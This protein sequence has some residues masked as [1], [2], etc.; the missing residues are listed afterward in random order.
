MG[1]AQRKYK[2]KNK[3]KKSKTDEQ[4]QRA[5]FLSADCCC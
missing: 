5:S 2:I 4:K 3:M 1:C